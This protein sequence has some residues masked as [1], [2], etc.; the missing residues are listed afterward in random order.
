METTYLVIIPQQ[1]VQKVYRIIANESLVFRIHEDVPILLR[2][3]SKYVIVL[4]V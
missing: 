3:S 2:K 1:L 4:A